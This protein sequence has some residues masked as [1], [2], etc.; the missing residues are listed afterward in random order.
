MTEVNL[1]PDAYRGLDRLEARARIVADVTAEGLAVMVPATDP[2]LGKPKA[3]TAPEEGGEERA[4]VPLVEPK[5]ITQPMGD[6]SKVVIEP[7][8]T[9]QWFVD[10]ARIVQPA[11]DAVR[12]GEVRI[13]P[14]Q[15]EKVYFN[16]LENIEPWCISRQLWWGHR[17]PVWWG[18]RVISM[19]A[20]AGLSKAQLRKWRLAQTDPSFCAETPEEAA[21]LASMYALKDAQQHSPE[22][23][24]VD[25]VV[26]D[27][28]PKDPTEASI[29]KFGT[30]LRYPIWRDP[31]VLDTWFSSGLWPQGTLGW[32]EDT[33]ELQRYFP[34]S[35]LVTG[36]DIIFFWVARMMM[37]SHATTGKSPFDTVY[38]HALV[39]DEKGKK[40]SKSLGNVIDP[41]ELIDEY[42]ADALRFTLTSMAAMGRDLKLSPARV[43]G[44]RNF[45]T[46][47]WNAFRFAEMNDALT[48]DAPPRPGAPANPV[49][50][51]IVGETAR[52]LAEVDAALAAYRFDAAANALY[53]FVWGRVCDWYLEMAK[54]LFDGDDAAET[55]A[56][57]AWV[58]AQCVIL[59]HPIMPFVTEALWK[60]TGHSTPLMLARWPDYTAE[61]LAD[62]AA[63]EEVS[64]VIALIEAIRSAR[65][66]MGVPAALKVPLLLLD[67]D[68]A[69]RA[70][71]RRHEALVMRLARLET[72]A[73]VDAIPRGAVTLPVQGGTFALPLAGLIDVAAE[74]ARL[75]KALLKL[76]KELSSLNGRLANDRF[77]ASA[78]DDVIDETR[79]L[80]SQKSEERAKLAAALARLAEMT[81]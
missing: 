47:L 18:K 57:M 40:M 19:Q 72:L 42:G 28:K 65:G 11:I 39:R 1:V 33:P 4:L 12:S 25:V 52:V 6:R 48:C 2:R 13:L 31:D 45:G 10:T 50:R 15:H 70:A 64:W 81:P 34:T 36:F 41:L 74:K 63:D 16:W 35:T 8:L 75:D 44:Y 46:K 26:F 66:E 27:T 22:V 20:I 60:E 58:L 62:P 7:M 55:R 67:L 38:V 5:T 43:E 73:V 56:T 17:V 51:W 76:D 54:P 59:L 49:N 14:E 9:D 53:A 37:M 21:K 68:D 29:G 32:P 61:D 79:A 69:G 77:I 3:P 78:P 23:T 80:A 71:W 24:D 30:S